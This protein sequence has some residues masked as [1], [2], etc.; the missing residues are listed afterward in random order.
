MVKHEHWN[1]RCKTKRIK[2]CGKMKIGKFLTKA[3][4]LKF[5]TYSEGSNFPYLPFRTTVKP[6]LSP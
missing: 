1:R 5:P 2:E 6:G 3:T 4:D